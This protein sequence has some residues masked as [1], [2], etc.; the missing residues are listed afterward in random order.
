MVKVSSLDKT[1]A[2]LSVNIDIEPE[3]RGELD[4]CKLARLLHIT[5]VISAT[6][7]DPPA[8]LDEN[9][10]AVASSVSLMSRETSMMELDQLSS[11]DNMNTTPIK[12]NFNESNQLR[13]VDDSYDEEFKTP[14]GSPKDNFAHQERHNYNNNSKD[15]LKSLH[16]QS[17][18]IDTPENTN[19]MMV[20]MQVSMKLPTV[21]LDLTYDTTLG[22]HLIL[23]LSQLNASLL[24]RPYDL[25]AEFGMNSISIEDSLRSE[26]QKYLAKTPNDCKLIHIAYTGISNKLSPLYNLHASE[27][28]VNFASLGLNCDIKTLTHLKPFMEVLLF[29]RQGNQSVIRRVQ[30]SGANKMN[31]TSTG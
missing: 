2:N 9:L 3:L 24:F 4:P 14:Q 11:R 17:L 5:Q 10:S 26:S 12:I 8:F 28:I 25:Q 21:I 16:S 23:T 13:E 6:F 1:D 27:I 31:N 30:S 15:H 19:A 20:R 22:H 7:T 18:P 29:M